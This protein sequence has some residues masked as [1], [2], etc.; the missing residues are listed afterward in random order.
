M[1]IVMA[2]PCSKAFKD[3]Q[4]PTKL[5]VRSLILHYRLQDKTAAYPSSYIL[6]FFP[7][8][9]LS[10]AKTDTFEGLCDW[11]CGNNKETDGEEME[12]ETRSR[13]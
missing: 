7:I 6:Y 5:S 10:S 8:L 9:T 13:I 2:P 3:L 12:G 4:L 11:L 1:A